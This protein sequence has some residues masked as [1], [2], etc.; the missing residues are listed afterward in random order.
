MKLR[1]FILTIISIA[2]SFFLASCRKDE[3]NLPITDFVKF[4]YN[5]VKRAYT[6]KDSVFQFCERDNFIPSKF[7]FEIEKTYPSTDD[8]FH[9]LTIDIKK[10]VLACPTNSLEENLDF[11]FTLT[12]KNTDSKFV[13]YTSFNI[14]DLIWTQKY[15]QEKIILMGDFKGWLYKYF[16]VRV[17]GFQQ[18]IEPVKLDSIYVDNGSFQLTLK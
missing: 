14:N 13:D 1:F 10:L 6:F 4:D 15:I 11:T 5:N 18:I 12:V 9:S 7:Q 17:T 8:Q 16:P 3:Q 2:A